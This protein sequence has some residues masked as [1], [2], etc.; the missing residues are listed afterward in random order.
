MGSL[1]DWGEDR[2]RKRTKVAEKRKAEEV[3]YL[4]WF[5]ISNLSIE[6]V[7]RSDPLVDNLKMRMNLSFQWGGPM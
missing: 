2:G 7:T 5:L 3:I 4:S 1:E 6:D